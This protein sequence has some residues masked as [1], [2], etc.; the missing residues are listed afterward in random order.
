MEGG[1]RL[2]QRGIAIPDSEFK[3]LWVQA[4]LQTPVMS[5]RFGKPV[6]AEARSR[7]KFGERLLKNR[8]SSCSSD[9]PP[10][11]LFISTARRGD[12]Y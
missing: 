12:G 4:K 7:R 3:P 2:M 8:S 1:L 5:Q 11:G 6:G 9:T 10:D